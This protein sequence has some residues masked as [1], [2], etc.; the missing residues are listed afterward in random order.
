MA[1]RPEVVDYVA[2]QIKSGTE[3]DVIRRVLVE[4]GWKE[5][6]V[7][8]AMSF[9]EDEKPKPQPAQP[10]QPVGMS[11]AAKRIAIQLDTGMSVEPRPEPVAE[12]VK[13]S[14]VVAPA[15]ALAAVPLGVDPGVLEFVKKQRAAGMADAAIAK[16]LKNEGARS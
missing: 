4:N 14:P 12:T 10:I 8:D 3:K 13:P 16:I 15:P 9:F 2:Q 6:D 11:D 7:N 1:V 5:D